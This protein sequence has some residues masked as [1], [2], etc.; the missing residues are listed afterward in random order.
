MNEQLQPAILLVSESTDESSHHCDD[1]SVQSSEQGQVPFDLWRSAGL[2]HYSHLDQHVEILQVKL[3]TS[4]SLSSPSSGHHHH[5]HH[6][7]Y[8]GPGVQEAGVVIA[9]FVW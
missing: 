2:R 5:Y 1:F 8:H 6:R 7:G 9:G 4:S 3:P